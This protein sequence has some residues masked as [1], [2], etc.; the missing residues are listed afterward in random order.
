MKFFRHSMVML[1]AAVVTA[2]G[3]GGGAN[4]RSSSGS[5]FRYTF[6]PH[7]TQTKVD[8][9]HG[10]NFK[11]NGVTVAV[12]DSGLRVTHNAFTGRIAGTRDVTTGSSS[13]TDANGHGTHVS[14]LVLGTTVNHQYIGVAPEANLLAVKVANGGTLSTTYY[15]KGIDYAVTHASNPK[16]INISAE[17]PVNGEVSTALQNAAAANRLIVVAA[18]NSGS[19]NPGGIGLFATDARYQGRILVVGSVNSSHTISTFSNRAGTQMN[20]YVVAPGENVLS[21]YNT[22]DS[23]HARLSGTSQAAP[24]VSGL[25]ALIWSKWPALTVAQVAD[26]IK[27]TATDLG[28]PGVDA[29]YGYGLINA[30]AAM[31]PASPPTLLSLGTVTVDSS[32]LVLPASFANL[33]S[34]PLLKAVAGIDKYGRDFMFD[35]SARVSSSAGAVRSRLF[36]SL[37]N[38]DV[39]YRTVTGS[40]FVTASFSTNN[41]MGEGTAKR[42]MSSFTRIGEVGVRFFDFNNVN[43]ARRLSG[44]EPLLLSDSITTT[45]PTSLVYNGTGLSLSSGYGNL[46]WHVLYVKGREIEGQGVSVSVLGA[47]FPVSRDSSLNIAAGVMTENGLLNASA[48][49]GFGSPVSV[50]RFIRLGGKY[51]MNSRSYL[52]AKYSMGNTRVSQG[53]SLLTDYS[54]LVSDAFNIGVHYG[55]R[56]YRAGLTVSSPLKIIRG[57]ARLTVPLGYDVNGRVITASDRVNLAPEG[58]EIDYELYYR[59]SKKN[60]AY[61]FNLVYQRQPG[62]V[63]T[64]SAKVVAMFRYQYRF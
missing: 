46:P 11:G 10:L 37:F 18:G 16:V 5:A 48:R 21:S 47:S 15:A 49:G 40:G 30:R 1:V 13:V 17:V 8:V 25:A 60:S 4:V 59:V 7:L 52:G 44:G 26:I 23:G 56:G 32:S 29:V 22:S 39:L 33:S 2:C 55:Y 14:G 53:V 19:S 38:Q 54:N 9:A 36:R 31:S 58:R 28:A 51:R 34:H 42:W 3:G 20:Y 45:S 43:L 63:V 64:A 41:V 24:Q 27:T 35:L 6:A 50:T 12:I 57:S 62:H 61:Q